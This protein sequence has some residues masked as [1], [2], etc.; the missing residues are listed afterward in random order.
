MP[1]RILMVD[2]DASLCAGVAR[3]LT[4]RGYEFRDNPDGR[5]VLDQVR[6]FQPQVLILNVELPRGSGYAICSKLRKD[7]GLK[8]TKV[9]LTSAEATQKAFDDHKKL[10]LGRADDYLLKPFEVDELSRKAVALLG[11]DFE[12]EVEASDASPELAFDSDD[13]AGEERIS[14]EDIEEIAVDEEL[15]PDE[16]ALPGERDVDL[17]ESAFQRL[18]ENSPEGGSPEGAGLNGTADLLSLDEPFE[19]EL[20]SPLRQQANEVLQ[21]LESEPD[22]RTLVAGHPRS[23]PAP[24]RRDEQPG[25]DR[26]LLRLREELN[27]RQKQLLDQRD[28]ETL[29][30]NEIARRKEELTRRDGQVRQLQQ[31]IDAL[32]AG[33]RR[34]EK[35]LQTSREEARAAVHRAELAER[36]RSA[37]EGQQRQQD[38]SVER[39]GADLESARQRLDDLQAETDGLRSRNE[40]LEAETNELRGRRAELE[41][42]NHKNEE[43]LV[44]AYQRLQDGEH[45]RGKTKQALTLALQLLDEPAEADEPENEDRP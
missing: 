36:A 14:L 29:L 39:L 2:S 26:E 30:E 18:E 38:D 11:D 31:R 35:D 15:G 33:Q 1:K 44:K 5:D 12:P 22:E 17:L 34:G 25:A 27:A 3:S 37:T 4:T 28:R 7:E 20:P 8:A 24:S 41:E 45:I 16:A 21:A 42:E 6:D 40:E 43:R 23:A 9:L 13:Q 32:I 10:K 19:Q